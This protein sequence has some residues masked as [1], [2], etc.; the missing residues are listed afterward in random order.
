MYLRGERVPFRRRYTPG[1]GPHAVAAA[2]AL[3]GAIADSP[4]G[5]PLQSRSRTGGSTCRLQ[6]VQATAH[7]EEVVETARRSLIRQLMRC[8]QCQGLRTERSRVLKAELILEAGHF[9]VAIVPLFAG[10]L[11]GAAPDAFG[12]ID[13]GGP[14]GSQACRLRHAFL[15]RGSVVGVEASRALTTF[16]RQALV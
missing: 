1:A 3:V 10:D 11:A 12:D 16:T 4:I 15:P 5:P 8:D 7:G 6:T 14:G 2:D 13:E 9:P